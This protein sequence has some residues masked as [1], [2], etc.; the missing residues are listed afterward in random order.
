MTV[1]YRCKCEN[2]IKIQLKV[3]IGTISFLKRQR[4]HRRALGYVLLLIISFGATVETVHS[5]GA[6]SLDRQGVAAF[7]DAGGSHP[8]H[9]GN[10]H[11][12]EC[13]LCEF[14]QHLFNGLVHA[15]LFALTPST[16]IASI[17][18]PALASPSTSITRPSGRAPPL[19]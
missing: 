4:P 13:P 14:Q 7:S 1:S 12:M 11:L 8:S 6:G 17:S 3:N 9:T 16:Q 10:T 18:A 15:P 5:H 19:G 2:H